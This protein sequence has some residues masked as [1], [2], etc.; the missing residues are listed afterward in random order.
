VA[1]PGRFDGAAIVMI[2]SLSSLDPILENTNGLLRE[3]FPRAPT[4][5][6]T[7]PTLTA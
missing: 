4:S 7:K 2:L 1:Q 6:T 3:Y 5:P